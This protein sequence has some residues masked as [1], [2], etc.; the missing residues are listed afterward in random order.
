MR[1]VQSQQL[2]SR[3]S[4]AQ[5]QVF[6]GT[7]S[8]LELRS[9]N[10]AVTSSSSPEVSPL[11]SRHS[12]R[13]NSP[14]M[15]SFHNLM[16]ARYTSSASSTCPCSSSSAPRMW[17]TGCIC[18]HGSLYARFSE[19]STPRRSSSNAAVK[20]CASPFAFARNC[21]RY[22]I[23]ASRIA[24]FTFRI[25]GPSAGSWSVSYTHLRAHET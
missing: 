14:H 3:A 4:C 9:L 20:S 7:M 25:E 8:A 13:P 11:A 10:N 2:F 18:P 16:S 12:L 21:L 24:A 23:S 17:R 1:D 5:K 22:S 15:L 6:A 19:R